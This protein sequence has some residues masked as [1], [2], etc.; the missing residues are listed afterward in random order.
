MPAPKGNQFAKGAKGSGNPGYGKIS[1]VLNKVKEHT[2]L[3]WTEWEKMIKH[4]QWD[5]RK[6]AMQEFNKLQVKLIPTDIESG[7][8]PLVIQF[9][10]TFHVITSQAT[11][12]S[13][14]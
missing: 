5:E 2:P 11:T 12:D 4:G 1:T 3:W 10:P 13:D 7:G 8:Q 6:V 9:D 14:E